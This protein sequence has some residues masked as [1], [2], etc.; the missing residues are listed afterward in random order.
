MLNALFF[1]SQFNIAKLICEL[2]LTKVGFAGVGN[3]IMDMRFCF[4]VKYFLVKV[5]PNF[6]SLVGLKCL[7]T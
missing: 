6:Q 5:F 7:L 3:G 1:L 2:N 4:D